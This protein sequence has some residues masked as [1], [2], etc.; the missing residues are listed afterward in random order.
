MSAKR[1]IEEDIESSLE[2]IADGASISEHARLLAK[3]HELRDEE[4]FALLVNAMADDPYFR[5]DSYK[6][7]QRE[8]EADE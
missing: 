1:T 2:D 3:D 7:F 5:S 6:V 4:A 8:A